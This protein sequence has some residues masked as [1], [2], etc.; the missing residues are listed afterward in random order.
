M[1]NQK[2]GGTTGV[3]VLA[4]LAVLGTAGGFVYKTVF[5]DSRGP[6]SASAAP[7]ATPSP[8]ASPSPSDTSA[9][10]AP[11]SASPKADAPAPQTP[12]ADAP[13]SNGAAS[14]VGRALAGARK[15]FTGEAK[16]SRDE[17][18][19]LSSL[20]SMLYTLRSQVA[21]YKLQH[22]DQWPDFRKYPGAE[23]LTRP[24]YEDGAFADGREVDDDGQPRRRMGPYM[25]SMM[26]NP[27]N[28][29]V[30]VAT[31]DEDVREG[32]TVT[33]PPGFDR[34][35]YVFSTAA[36]GQIW[37]TDATGLRVFDP[38]AALARQKMNSPGGRQEV[39]VTTLQTLRSQVQL[40]RLQHQ[41]NIPDLRRYP[42]WDQLL[43]KTNADGS[44]SPKGQYGPYLRDVPV[45]PHNGFSA[46]ELVDQDPPAGFKPKGAEIGWVVNSDSGI[47]WG[48]DAK[49]VVIQR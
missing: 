10:D 33:P 25:Q 13:A 16:Q 31:V 30:A 27:L 21:L 48:T 4:V 8:S 11:A 14:G 20:V 19:R 12:K 45:N 38:E 41:D 35:G 49:G 37:A 6:A 9:T 42:K 29:S 7:A 43:K 28:G 3:A 1:G 36:G 22:N 5:L 32:E 17:A 24:T 18:A 47:L 40:Y 44:I 46:A 15:L 2:S 39:F 26:P 34:V 23:Q